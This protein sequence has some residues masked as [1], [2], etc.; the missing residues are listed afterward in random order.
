[1]CLEAVYAL[2]YILYFASTNMVRRWP[3][4]PLDTMRVGLIWNVS[5][6]DFSGSSFISYL[7]FFPKTSETKDNLPDNC[8]QQTEKAQPQESL[9]RLYCHWGF[10]G[11]GPAGGAVQMDCC[12]RVAVLQSWVG[13]LAGCFQNALMAATCHFELVAVAFWGVPVLVGSQLEIS[14]MAHQGFQSHTLKVLRH[15]TTCATCAP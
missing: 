11:W 4:E 10:S 15:G 13:W 9:L 6:R 8:E 1:M 2:S 3:T 12:W 5:Y 7:S 14:P